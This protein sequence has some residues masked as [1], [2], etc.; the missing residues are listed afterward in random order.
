MKRKTGR[1][2]YL[3]NYPGADMTPDEWEFL[4]A[5]ERFQRENHRRY[6]TFREV[7]FVLESLGYRK[8]KPETPPPV[9][10]RPEE[11]RKTEATP[12]PLPSQGREPGG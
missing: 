9:P 4:K 8:A 11:G 6:P 1:S 12:L 7:L 10:P 5:M 2:R 3:E